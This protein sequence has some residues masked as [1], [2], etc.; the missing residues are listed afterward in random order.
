MKQDQQSA[1]ET[2]DDDDSILRVFVDHL[3]PLLKPYETTLYLY[4]LRCTRLDGRAA[5]RIGIRTISRDCGVGTR[6]SS[7]GN[8]QHIR[9]VLRALEAKGCLEVGDRTR[10]GTS[11]TV[12]LPLEV[13]A[14][15]EQ[16]LAATAPAKPKDFY[17][18]PELRKGLFERDEWVCHYCGERVTEENATL[19]HLV[20]VSKDGADSAENLVTACLLC[21]SLKSGKTYEEAAPLILASIRDRRSRAKP[22]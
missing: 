12:R 7:G 9:E 19:D 6:S 11:Y 16:M 3:M 17:R 2:P 14:A 4:L 15:W 5:T 22:E 8:Q 21:N 10:E 13:A 18:D 1:T 20:P